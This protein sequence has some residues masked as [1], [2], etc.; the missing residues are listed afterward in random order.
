[1]LPA[2]PIAR[3]QTAPGLT[4]LRRR[5]VKVA[6]VGA[7]HVAALG[8]LLTNGLALFAADSTAD[9]KSQSVGVAPCACCAQGQS[10]GW[11]FAESD[12]FRVWCQ[13]NCGA[14]D[15]IA[16]Q[17]ECA[18]S[19]LQK[20]WFGKDLPADWTPKCDVVVHGSAEEYVRAVG[21]GSERTAGSSLVTVK[22]GRVVSRRLDL[23]A[24]RGDALS[25]VPH[26]LTHVVLADRFIDRPL[27]RWADEGMATLA[28]S[29]TKRG[30]HRRD[31]LAAV[32][33]R[34]DLRVAELLS[35]DGYPSGA[36]WATFYGQSASLVEFLLERGE[37]EALVRF[38][39]QAHLGGYDAALREVYG[40]AGV[41]A[42]EKQWKASVRQPQIEPATLVRDELRRSNRGG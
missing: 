28:D 30:E 18:R 21:Q 17:C 1:M 35:M 12:N 31:L 23:R 40:I 37:P 13:S 3:R 16:K 6:V 14:A 9:R 41:A 32:D 4:S 24:D 36:T 20:K 33:R 34:S 42:L 10:G 39:S 29:A 2:S 5:T 38:V 19:D 15:S 11:H 25:A 27:P 22:A 7:A 26:E 8:A